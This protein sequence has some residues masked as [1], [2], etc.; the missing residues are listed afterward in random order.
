MWENRGKLAL[1]LLNVRSGDRHRRLALV[2]LGDK[3]LMDVGSYHGVRS[4]G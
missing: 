1:Y 3:Q 2:K 4:A